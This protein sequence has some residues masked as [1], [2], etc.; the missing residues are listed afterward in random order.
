ML[1]QIAA[2]LLGVLVAFLVVALV[3]RLGHMVFPPPAELAGA[4]AREIAA[5]IERLPFGALLFVVAAWGLGSFT[6][7]A[8]ASHL[9][10]PPSV[11]P[12]LAVGAAVLGATL[13]TLFN[14]PHPVWMA[15][16]GAL[17]PLP[18]AWLGYRA[19]RR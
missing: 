19:V 6:G 7:A 5:A 14:L 13:L 8:V 2:A 10:R 11:V 1:R 3:Q 15:L 9:A 18:A 4:D 16:A 17:L 12:G